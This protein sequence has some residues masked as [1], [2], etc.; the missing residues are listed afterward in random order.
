VDGNLGNSRQFYV[1]ETGDVDLDGLVDNQDVD[2][3]LESFLAADGGEVIA[4]WTDGDINGDGLVTSVDVDLIQNLVQPEV[5]LGD[6][7]LDDVV[8]FADIPAFI[9]L[10]QSGEYLEEADINEDGMVDFADIPALIALLQS[11]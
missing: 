6:V 2:I 7:N 10:I 11:L 1:A 3:V 5:L 4:L 8:N 9:S